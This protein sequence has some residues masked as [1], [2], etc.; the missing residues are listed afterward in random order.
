MKIGAHADKKKNTRPI[1]KATRKTKTT[2]LVHSTKQRGHHSTYSARGTHSLS[3]TPG[4][5]HRVYG[6]KDT[7]RKKKKNTRMYTIYTQTHEH[8]FF[9]STPSHRG[10]KVLTRPPRLGFHGKSPKTAISFGTQVGL[11]EHTGTRAPPLQARGRS[12]KAS[13]AFPTATATAA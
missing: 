1:S 10:N 9:E 7:L 12:L 13:T 8:R 2:S 6:T 11:K 3:A 4:I 5:Q